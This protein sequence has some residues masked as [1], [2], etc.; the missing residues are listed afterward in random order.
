MADVYA[1][2]RIW[3][4]LS[5]GIGHCFVVSSFGNVTA[6]ATI[7]RPTQRSDCVDADAAIGA[8]AL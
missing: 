3:P 2:R 8:P 4:I 5:A 1:I 7:A 6:G